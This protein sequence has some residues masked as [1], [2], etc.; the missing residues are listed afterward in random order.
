MQCITLGLIKQNPFFQ[1]T[2][3][4]GEWT[5][6]LHLLHYPSLKALGSR[7]WLRFFFW[8]S[9]TENWPLWGGENEN[10]PAKK[11]H[12]TRNAERRSLH[13]IGLIQSITRCSVMDFEKMWLT[14]L[15]STRLFCLFSFFWVG[16]MHYESPVKM[17]T[18]ILCVNKLHGLAEAFLKLSLK[19]VDYFSAPLVFCSVEQQGL[20]LLMTSVAAWL[21]L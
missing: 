17:Q 10:G 4:E 14:K 9:V 18:G 8:P 1:L 19:C 12:N 5:V 21:W 16:L 15:W 13:L 3:R 2:F 11:Q 6:A 7:L 20:H